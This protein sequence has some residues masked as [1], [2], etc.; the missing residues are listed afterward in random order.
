L[1]VDPTLVTEIELNVKGGYEGTR[2]LMDL[3]APPD[4]LVVSSDR[5]S[6]GCLKALRDLKIKVPRDISVV[7]MD[8]TPETAFAHPPL[9]AVE[10]PWYDMLALGAKL[11]VEMIEQRPPI[12]QI[13]ICYSTRL[14]IRESTRQKPAAD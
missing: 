1:A 12:E 6:L 4:A 7:A 9:T 14:V 5:A 10:I 11:L 2:R 13:G 3:P 8:G